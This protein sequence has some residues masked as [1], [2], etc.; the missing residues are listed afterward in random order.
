[1]TILASFCP[2]IEFYSID[3][4]FLSL[5]SFTW[6]NL[7]QYAMEIRL[8]IKNCI[9]LPVAIGI[10]PTKTLA[11]IANHVAK[12]QIT[13]GIYN[14]CDKALQYEILNTFSIEDLWGI[15]RRLTK[16][17]Y[18]FNISTAIALRDSPIKIMR[19]EFGVIM[20]RIIQELQGISCLPL[21]N[22]K[23]RNKSSLLDLLVN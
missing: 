5:D 9:G 18:Q 10:G 14:L 22:V 2:D 13:N 8:P 4:A 6:K 1:M 19:A 20:E 23:P 15:G 11:K 7:S 16:R 17:L 12:K 21:E 3:E